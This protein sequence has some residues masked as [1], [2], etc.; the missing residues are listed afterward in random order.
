MPIMQRLAAALDAIR[1][2]LPSAKRQQDKDADMYRQLAEHSLVGVYLIQDGRF[3]Y[4]NPRMAEIF[5]YDRE[6]IIRSHTVADLVAPEDR[7]L[8][9]ENIR[10]RMAA[11]V[12]T[13]QYGFRA[14]RKDGVVIEVEVLGTRVE[15]LGRPAVVGTLLDVTERNR[16]LQES[17]L[18]AD[19]LANTAE[20]VIVL[21]TA[22]RIISVNSAFAGISGYSEAEALQQPIESL[23]S[24]WH[25]ESFYDDIW[26]TVQHEGKWQGEVWL[27][28]KNGE[29]FASLVGVSSVG[30]PG[31]AISHYVVVV[32]DISRFKQVEARLDFLSHYDPVTRLPNRV[33]FHQ[34]LQQ[35]LLSAHRGNRQVAVLL[36][37]LDRFKQ[38]NESLGHAAG[39]VLLQQ[40]AARLREVAGKNTNL[41][42]VGGDEFVVI[43]DDMPDTDSAARLAGN[44]LATMARP[45]DIEG[46]QVFFTASIGISCFPNDGTDNETLFKVADAAL[47]RA[48]E[49]GRNI[50][51]FASSEMNASALESLILTNNL[52]TALEKKE[53][54]LEYQPIVNL[55]DA[56]LSGV[57]ALLRWR[58]PE[59]GVVGPDAFIPL[60]EQTG[61]IGNIGHWVLQEACFQAVRWRRAGLPPVTVAVNLSLRQVFGADCVR[62]IAGVLKATG[63]EPQWLKIEVTESIM[64]SDPEHAESVFRKIAAMG[65]KIAL[66]DFG[67]GYSS[68]SH[69]KR[70]PVDYLKIDR[71]FVSDLPDDA[72][73]AAITRAIVA[74]GGGLGIKQ[75]AEGIETEAQRNYL[76]HAGCLEGQ[77]FLFSRPVRPD[78]IAE[79]L[80]SGFV[81]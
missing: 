25:A 67:V 80:A 61:L 47:L 24:D 46:H 79:M 59:L 71:S 50:F 5:G 17:R 15:Y 52:R 9:L 18:M 35:I 38:I 60:A 39:D 51:Q 6:E 19:A 53:L 37:G 20:A 12:Q 1:R 77:G 36:L 55:A 76:L 57:E 70:L 16:V 64:M 45:V 58:H 14:L 63:M 40:V 27:K 54:Y 23:R 65:V 30:N 8:V 42:R 62:Q 22:R 10:R 29:V 78:R 4:V 26:A 33:F 49:R 44:M 41:S 66:D 43:L 73:D 32:N 72:N 48:K 2:W 34:H 11:E 21:D 31:S 68:L 69:L 7:T 13:V 56:S 81:R 74:M 75:V 28:R 3:P